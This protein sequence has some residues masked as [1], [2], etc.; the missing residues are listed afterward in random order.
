M[1]FIPSHNA[2]FHEE[3]IGELDL[4]FFVKNEIDQSS[5]GAIHMANRKTGKKSTLHL[6]REYEGGNFVKTI[7]WDQNDPNPSNIIK[8]KHKNIITLYHESN[9]KALNRLVI[10]AT[11]NLFHIR[12]G[13]EGQKPGG[14]TGSWIQETSDESG[15][16][17][18]EIK[19]A[20]T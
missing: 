6:V 3:C 14:I 1:Q 17:F 20:I 18:F 8:L 10:Q 7:Y 4:I 9:H 19:K 15:S 11:S 5:R 13:L 12:M 16:T 2:F